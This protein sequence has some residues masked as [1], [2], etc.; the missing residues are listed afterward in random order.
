MVVDSSNEGPKTPVVLVPSALPTSRIFLIGYR[1]TGKTTVARILAERLGWDWVDA[2]EVLENRYGRSI[3]RIFAEDGEAAFRR[4]ESTILEELSS[5]TN[6]VLSTGGGVVLNPANRDR[7]RSAGLVVW[8]TADTETIWQR[9]QADQRTEEGRPKL[10]VGGLAEIQQM[11]QI[12][13]PLYRECADLTVDTVGRSATE[14]AD[15]I[16]HQWVNKIRS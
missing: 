14:V 11:L 12:R 9:L 10:S 5:R 13:E 6:S 8:L 3:R 1:G 4:M 15:L 16:L 2:D 7:M